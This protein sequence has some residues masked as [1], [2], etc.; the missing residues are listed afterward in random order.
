MYDRTN[1]VIRLTRADRPVQTPAKD[2]QA[3]QNDEDAA[4]PFGES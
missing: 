3:T 1:A 4:M 2:Q